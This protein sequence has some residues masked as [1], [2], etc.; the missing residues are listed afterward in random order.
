VKTAETVIAE[1]TYYRWRKE[2]GEL[3]VEQAKRTVQKTVERK[4]TAQEGGG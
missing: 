4:Q 3:W 2:Y 1:Q